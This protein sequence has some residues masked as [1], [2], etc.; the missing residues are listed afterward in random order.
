MT[1]DQ[2]RAKKRYEEMLA[3]P[4]RLIRWGAVVRSEE[5]SK[6]MTKWLIVAY[7]AFLVYGVDFMKKLYAK[8]KELEKLLEKPNKNEWETLRVKELQGKLRTRDVSKLKQYAALKEEQPDLENFDGIVLENNDENKLNEMILPARDTTDFYE[9][10]ADE[11]DKSISFEER[12]IG[13]G[14]R[15]KWVMKHCHG[16]VLEVSCGTGRN[17]KY[18]NP[19]KINSI[20]FL[21]SSEKMV[22]IT[23]KKFKDKFG[24]F[25]KVAFVVGYAENLVDLAKTNNKGKE[26]E[27]IRVKYDT[28]VETFGLCSH[29]DPVK[30]LNNFVTLLKPGGRIILLEHGRGTYDFINKILDRR[31]E[32]R[33][34]TWGCRWNLDLGEIL[35]DSDLEI[36]EEKRVHLGTTWCIVAKRKGDVKKKEEIAFM[37]KYVGSTLKSKL[38]SSQSNIK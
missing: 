1:K 23:E 2:E 34:A 14:K 21:D 7:I 30:A 29:E 13:L 26:G 15:R 31:A 25:K 4:Y 37:E 28:I 20:T 27:D 8:D 22:E 12:M 33:L 9:H 10:K 19:E 6:G 38:E 3:S 5:F 32:K 17:I 18:L 36:V 24:F 16:D 35:D 11:Y